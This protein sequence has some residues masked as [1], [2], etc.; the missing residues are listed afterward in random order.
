MNIATVV[1]EARCVSCGL[2]KS[3]CPVDAIELK[4]QKN[5][6]V[7]VPYVNTNKCINCGKCWKYCAAQMTKSCSLLG[8]M[9]V[10]YLAHAKSSDIRKGATSGGVINRVINYLLKMD[11]VEAVILVRHDINS[12]IESSVKILTKSGVDDLNK[13]REYSSR[14][15]LVP[16]LESVKE[17][18]HKFSKVAIVGTPCQINA[19]SRLPH[20]N[21]TLWKI[22]IACSGGMRY[23]ATEEYKRVSGLNNS[24]MFYRGN[25]WPGHNTLIHKDKAIDF[26][27]QGSLFERMFSSQIFKIKGCRHCSDQFA[28]FADISFCDFWNSDELKHEKIGN[29][30]VIIRN[31]KAEQIINELIENNEIE[32]VKQLGKKEIIDSQKSVLQAKKGNLHEN[33]KYK[34]FF[35]IIDLIY[36]L[37]LYRIFNVKVY[38]RIAS[39]Y[40]KLC[41]ESLLKM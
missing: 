14:Y 13:S 39:Y 1:N 32:V 28:E 4:Y 10:G 24:E 27:H 36:Y 3:V 7:F 12:P 2:C 38:N 23:T 18:F 35:L 16:V 26:N 8:E 6:G 9:T 22:G 21:V 17:A 5:K 33:K 40:L 19:I 30:C 37:K 15:V 25:G 20:P 29:S 34:M 11:Y 31:K 41:R